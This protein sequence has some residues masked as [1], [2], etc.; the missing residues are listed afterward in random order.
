M[1]QCHPYLSFHGN[2]REALEFYAKVTG[3]EIVSLM[4]YGEAPGDNPVPDD[5]KPQI[6]HGRITFGNTLLM[7]SDVPWGE[8]QTPAGFN[9]SLHVDSPEE[10]DRVFAA[11]SEGGT[12][13][14]PLA[15]SFFARRFGSL[16]DKFGVPWIVIS[17]KQTA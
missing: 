14:Y 8:K 3:G 15:E 5:F 2:C 4:T 6:M 10:A 17:E 11:L 13:E 7:A 1:T 12:V 16:H 9:V